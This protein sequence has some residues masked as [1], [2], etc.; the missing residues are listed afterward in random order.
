MWRASRRHGE[1]PGL[2]ED[3]GAGAKQRN[4]NGTGGLET[5][6]QR[7]AILRPNEPAWWVDD[8]VLTSQSAT[9]VKVRVGTG[10]ALR[11]AVPAPNLTT[12][13]VHLAQQSGLSVLD[14]TLVNRSSGSAGKVPVY[15]VALA[16]GRVVAAGRAVVTALAGSS[17]TFRIFLVGNPAGAR[18]EL[19]VAPTAG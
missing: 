2:V 18:V 13:G 3:S 4:T 6:L 16:S 19:T 9:G 1:W 7:M 14:G 5:L 17:S 12:T 11:T 8:Q 10:K 15:A